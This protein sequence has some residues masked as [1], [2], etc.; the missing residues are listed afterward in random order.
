MWL[1]RLL[2][3]L[4]P[5]TC[6]V[7]GS[8]GTVLCPSCKGRLPLRPFRVAHDTWALFPYH[9]PVAGRVIQAMKF[10]G[11]AALADVS[12]RLLS[13]ALDGIESFPKEDMVI[14]P[15]PSS[16]GE[17]DAR[18]YDHISLISGSL[19]AHAGLSVLPILSKVR[20][21]ERQVTMKNRHRRM[22]NLRSAFL[23]S[24]FSDLS[25]KTFLVIDD[26]TTTGATFIEA[27]RALET[28]GAKNIVF[29]AL[30]H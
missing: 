11:K 25:E 6:V 9:H 28:V 21:T 15:I 30:A 20:E 10:E 22:E 8:E 4:F 26:V 1:K 18:G 7:C 5:P 16:T 3:F 14:V 23:A 13:E 27:R 17:R 24:E 29:L 12:G 2:S 19:G